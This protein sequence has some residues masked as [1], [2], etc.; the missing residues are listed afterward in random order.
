[1]IDR[2]LVNGNIHTLDP[3]KPHATSL[4][5]Q[6]ERIAAVGDDDL[7][8]LATATTVID[9]LQGAMVLPGLVDAHIHWEGVARALKSI[10]LADLPDKQAALQRV[11]QAAQKAAPGA[12]LTGR[13]WSQ[14]AWPDGAF[15][16]A[17]DLDS[18]APNH[19]VYL[20]A[21]SGHAAWV[22]SM[23]LRLAGIT[24]STP[25]PF[26]GA[27]QHDESGQVTGILFE[28]K[29][30]DQVSRLIPTPTTTELAEMMIDAQRLAW[31]AGLTGIH[32]FDDP[33]A[34]AALE[35][36]H[37]Q[38]RLGLR[39]VKNINK[40]FIQHALEL[41]LRW[42]FGNDWLRIGGLKLFA[43]GAL[44]SLTAAM[45]EPYEGQPDN[46]GIV[47]TD[48]EEMIELVNAASVAGLPSTIHAIGDRAVH[49]VLDVYETV[50]R[51]EAGRG[52]Q[53][54]ARRHR[55][56]HVQLIHP[57]DIG[58]LAALNVIASMQPIH[59]TSDYQMAD[60]YWGE[61]AQWSYNTRAQIDARTRVAFGSDAPVEPFELLKGIHA[62]V[63]RRRADGSPGPEGWYPDARLTMDEALRGYTQGPA[64][65]AGMENRLGTIAHNF[66]AD[67]V[68]LDSDL[69][70]TQ[71]ILNV[72]VVGTMSGGQ[73]RFGSFA[74]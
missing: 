2:L 22:N 15:P 29:A 42:G 47:V 62:A 45:I 74:G 26:G 37:E 27:I 73:W 72:Q 68:V 16:T 30:M 28:D 56:E 48:K 36:L 71:D 41:R 64:F 12:W 13:G 23:A 44:G 49:D 54:I 67:L 17:A 19:P 52:V 70:T 21:R 55:I 60:R 53:P 9:D 40:P 39:V 7:R 65:A 33:S 57:E 1:M 58:R 50:R 4:A 46:R 8:D 32:D 18:V 11:S 66:L 38:D 69:Y 61:R 24:D 5:L 34:F 20:A 63:T 43:D 59:A 10:D 14:S 31:Q 3:K 6:H 35:L 51:E 25:D